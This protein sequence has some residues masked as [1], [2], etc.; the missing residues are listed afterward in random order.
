MLSDLRNRKLDE[1]P[2]F[3]SRKE[4]EHHESD[5]FLRNPVRLIA[6]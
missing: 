3:A 4:A 1:K 5:S 6:I 2:S